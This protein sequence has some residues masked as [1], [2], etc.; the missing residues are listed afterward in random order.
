MPNRFCGLIGLPMLDN[1]I[2]RYFNHS[3]LFLKNY[4][5]FFKIIIN[6]R[7]FQSTLSLGI[8]ESNPNQRFFR[9]PAKPFAFIL[10]K[11]AV[12]AFKL[13][14]WGSNPRLLV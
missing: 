12:C 5:G 13:L 11:I 3:T 2:E 1:R 6:F 9:P 7:L 8:G 4:I 10:E 14:E